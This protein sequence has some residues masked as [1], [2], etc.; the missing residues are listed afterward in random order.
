MENLLRDCALYP[1]GVLALGRVG[2]RPEESRRGLDV[3]V[4]V[5]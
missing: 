2:S 3:V 1:V 4:C 5:C